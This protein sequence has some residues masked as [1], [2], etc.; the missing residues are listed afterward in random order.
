MEL[1]YFIHIVE[2]FEISK[3]LFARSP[4]YRFNDYDCNIEL[5]NY[6]PVCERHL[7]AIGNR[8]YKV[9]VLRK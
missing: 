9:P 6:Y 2:Y 8:T 4:D 1:A 7:W 5:R 3:S